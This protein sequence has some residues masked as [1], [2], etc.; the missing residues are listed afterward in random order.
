MARL[1]SVAASFFSI[2]AKAA[3]RAKVPGWDV[4]SRHLFSSQPDVAFD[5]GLVGVVAAEATAAVPR[6]LPMLAGKRPDS[7]AVFEFEPDVAREAEKRPAKKQ[8]APNTTPAQ[9]T[10]TGFAPGERVETV[11]I[12]FMA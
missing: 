6:E 3:L 1:G 9:I 8:A 10:N 12:W 11:D 7:F 2:S 5:T 4:N